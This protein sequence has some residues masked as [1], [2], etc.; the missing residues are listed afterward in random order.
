[1]RSGIMVA[2]PDISARAATLTATAT[3]CYA[4]RTAGRFPSSNAR[5][6]MDLVERHNVTPQ[7]AP[8]SSS[9]VS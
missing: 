2:S 6:A 4:A 7:A 5:Q 9:S 3:S 8:E 1:M